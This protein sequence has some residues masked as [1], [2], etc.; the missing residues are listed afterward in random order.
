MSPDPK[1]FEP[2]ILAWNSKLG[3]LY[4]FARTHDEMLRAYLRIFQRM[5]AEGHYEGMKGCAVGRYAKAK[6]GD[7]ESAMALIL[8]RSHLEYCGQ[9]VRTIEPMVP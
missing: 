6:A 4:V 1:D 7:V 5:D 8:I 9:Q 2:H 3:V